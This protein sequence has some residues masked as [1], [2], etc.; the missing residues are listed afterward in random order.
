MNLRMFR[1][2]ARVMTGVERSSGNNA[3]VMNS[4][5]GKRFQQASASFSGDFGQD[6]NPDDPSAPPP[7]LPE[8]LPGDDPT[9]SAGDTANMYNLPFNMFPGG[10]DP[11]AAPG[12]PPAAPTPGPF[13]PGAAPVPTPAPAWTGV[14]PLRTSPT[15][16]AVQR[17]ATALATPPQAGQSFFSTP[18][19]YATIGVG[20]LGGIALIGYFWKQ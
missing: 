18:M 11:D 6:L 7:V 16:Q 15:A 8:G 4:L 9:T 2:N 3:M 14:A 1:N 10:T 13:T 17:G 12:G 20:A 5:W 19:G